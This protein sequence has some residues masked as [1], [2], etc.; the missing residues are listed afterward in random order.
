MRYGGLRFF[1][2]S[3]IAIGLADAAATQEYCVACSQPNAV[4]RCVIVT[5]RPGLA[6]SLQ[7]SCITSLAKAGGH[8]QCSVQ[9]GV[10]VF[11][12]DGPV[13]KVALDQADGP[14]LLETQPVAAAPVASSVSDEPPATVAEAAKR[15]KVATDRQFKETGEQ[16]QKA[17]EATES[18]FKK[19]FTCIG[20]MFT[21]CS[22]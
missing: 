8:G 16:L 15:A 12:C 10:T 22:R 9:R 18:F 3:M 14:V 5:A 7:M 1:A 17:G 11:E 19:A 4:Y 21:R 6:S 20:S 2:I 13:K